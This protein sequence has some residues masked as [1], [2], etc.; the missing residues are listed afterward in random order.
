MFRPRIAV[1]AIVI[2]LLFATACQAQP[3]QQSA[4]P[5]PKLDNIPTG[6]QAAL[7]AGGCF[8]CMEAPFDKIPGVLSTTSG[9][10]DGFVKDPAY[11]KVANGETGHTEAVQIVFDPKKVTYEKLLYVFWRNIDPTAK[12]RQFCD[13]GTQYRSGVYAYGQE[14]LTAARGSLDAI[15]KSGVV[16]ETIYTEIKP[17]TRFYAAETYHQD[18]Y[19]KNPAHYYRYRTGCGRDA[20]LKLIWGDQAGG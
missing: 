17:A 7:F 13:G 14:Q 20:R 4:K 8:W 5:P 16:K 3:T 18:F 1:P 6:M 15:K 12:D 11:R 9:Y 2:G 19:K 10:T